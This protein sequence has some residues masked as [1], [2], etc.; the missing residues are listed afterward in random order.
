MYRSTYAPWFGESK[1]VAVT[2]IVYICSW[3]A[4]IYCRS[5]ASPS[6]ELHSLAFLARNNAYS[7]DAAS[8]RCVQQQVQIAVSLNRA[9][10]IHALGAGLGTVTLQGV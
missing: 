4:C 9:E 8:M 6:L 10:Q 1:G 3:C 5:E 7:T 2:S